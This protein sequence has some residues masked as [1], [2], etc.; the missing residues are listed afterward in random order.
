M[1]ICGQ[2]KRQAV[3]ARG[4][5]PVLKLEM[6]VT[7]RNVLAV[8]KVAVNVEKSH[9]LDVDSVD[10]KIFVLIVSFQIRK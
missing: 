6:M 10:C 8:L 4:E 5:K 1:L 7:I 2:E 9:Q 3:H